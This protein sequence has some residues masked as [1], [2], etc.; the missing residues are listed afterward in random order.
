MELKEYAGRL[1]EDSLSGRIL[2]VDDEA[3]IL[4]AIRAILSDVGCSVEICTEAESALVMLEREAFDV[5]I[6]DIRMP[7]M[8][9]IELLALIHQQ[10][11]ETPVILISG[12]ADMETAVAAV[13]EHAFDFIVKPFDPEHIVCSVR[14]AFGYKRLLDM[15]REY[16]GLL[17]ETVA[18]SAAG[19]KQYLR[20]LKQARDEALEAS[21]LKS[22][23]IATISHEI[24]TPLNGLVG[25]IDLLMHKDQLPHQKEYF[26]M[27]KDAA[28]YLTTLLNNILDFSKLSSGRI[29]LD[30]REFS[31]KCLLD[32]VTGMVRVRAGKKGLSFSMNRVGDVPE[33]LIGDETRLS[34]VLINLLDNALKFTSHGSITL[35]IALTD[36]ASHDPSGAVGIRFAV[37][38]TGSGIEPDRQEMIF[39][40][41]NQADGSYT[42]QYGGAGLGLSIAQQIVQA[43]GGRI[44]V[45]SSPGQGSTFS[46]TVIMHKGGGK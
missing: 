35:D 39:G 17:E 38:D 41:F 40:G 31:L 23:F 25:L 24:R 13:K 7:G 5:I 4:K 42:K 20:Q 2:V 11:P 43:M 3:S 44:S 18:K 1:P 6:S 30:E 8:S 12:Y 22:Q 27:M 45:E 28:D 21:R 32:S 10:N 15:E 26:S 46:F 16:K 33:M 9:G 37:S 34:Q 29:V 36:A 19:V 14:K